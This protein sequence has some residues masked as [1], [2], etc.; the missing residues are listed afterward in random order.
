M[1]L[2]IG[3]VGCSREE[4]LKE[5]VYSVALFSVSCGKV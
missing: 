4:A 2:L 5:Q 1:K 3:P